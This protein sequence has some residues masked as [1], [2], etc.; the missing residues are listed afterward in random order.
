[1][2]I[3]PGFVLIFLPQVRYVARPP[4]SLNLVSLFFFGPPANCG[5]IQTFYG[6][7]KFSFCHS[8]Q[9]FPALLEGQ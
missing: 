6:H 3:N 5:M 1:M 9:T 4:A 7:K 2:V 8:F